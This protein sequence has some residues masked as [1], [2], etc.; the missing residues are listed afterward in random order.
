MLEQLFH[1]QYSSVLFPLG[2]GLSLTLWGFAVSSHPSNS[3]YVGAIIAIGFAL[4]WFLGW[5]WTGSLSKLGSRSRSSQN[6]FGGVLLAGLLSFLAV[7]IFVVQCWWMTNT[8]VVIKTN[9]K[10]SK[11]LSNFQ[12]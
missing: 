12:K 1:W 9:I 10:P 11:A 3:I 5:I 7:L 6:T 4:V 2:W 8:W